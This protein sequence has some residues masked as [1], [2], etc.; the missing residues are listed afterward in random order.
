MFL[1]G[2]QCIIGSH[3][4][5]LWHHS[6]SKPPSSTSSKS[7][8]NAKASSSL[9]CGIPSHWASILWAHHAKISSLVT[10]YPSSTSHFENG[11]FTLAHTIK[12]LRIGHALYNSSFGFGWKLVKPMP[13]I[14]LPN[15]TSSSPPTPVLVYGGAFA[16][17]GVLGHVDPPAQFPCY[18]L[19]VSQPLPWWHMALLGPKGKN[20]CQLNLTQRMG[21]NSSYV[22]NLTGQVADMSRVELIIWAGLVYCQWDGGTL[23]A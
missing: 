4:E 17:S 11:H 1:A 5:R 12:S 9:V 8:R 3:V 22:P 20:L 2:I 18:I 15:L 19:S 23:H 21:V 14:E 16:E 10:S 13:S 7:L 6:P